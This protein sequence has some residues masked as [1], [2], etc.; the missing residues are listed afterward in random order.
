M[1]HEYKVGEMAKGQIVKIMEFGAFA[2]IGF[3]TEGLI[4]ISEIAPFRVEKVTDFLKEGDMV[5]LK[6]IKVDEKG[7]INFSI[8]EADREFFKPIKNS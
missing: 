1:T 8:K 5:P 2:K 4:H 3:D 6:I 7:R